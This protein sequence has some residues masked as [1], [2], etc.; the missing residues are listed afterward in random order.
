[1]EENSIGY[2]NNNF[3]LN[4]SAKI[5]KKI[6]IIYPEYISTKELKMLQTKNDHELNKINESNLYLQQQ[7]IFSNKSNMNSFLNYLNEIFNSKKN[8]NEDSKIK[9]NSDNIIKKHLIKKLKNK[10]LNNPRKLIEN[11]NKFFPSNLLDYIHPYEYLFNHK[12]NKNNHNTN[13]NSKI[14][15][16]EKQF[17]L[18][19]SDIDFIPKKKTKYFSRN[20]NK[21]TI[22][23]KMNKTETNRRNI[24]NK[25]ENKRCQTTNNFFNNNISKIKKSRNKKIF[26]TDNSST[27]N[28]KRQK[29]L[30]QNLTNITHRLKTIKKE[31]ISEYQ[32]KDK[33]LAN[34]EKSNQILSNFFNNNIN[35]KIN[36]AQLIKS[37]FKQIKKKSFF[38][39]LSQQYSSNNRKAFPTTIK[40]RFLQQLLKMDV[41]EKKEKILNTY[42]YN[43]D[44]ILKNEFNK[45]KENEISKNRRLFNKNIEKMKN[46]NINNIK[47]FLKMMNNKKIK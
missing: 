21:N 47:S 35:S 31:L 4:K 28:N 33:N 19:L 29:E 14:N 5:N 17:E 1:M 9:I 16:T 46:L 36:D 24:S 23:L 8:N 6:K 3:N 13:S 20:Q 38:A 42:R 30:F 41:L 44:Y 39:D 7:S 10:R 26:L 2:R 37:L 22:F 45:L 12:I 32:N 40:K 34:E 27:I 11:K 15:K 18:H 25:Y 43:N